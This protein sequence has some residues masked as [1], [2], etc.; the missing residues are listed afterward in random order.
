MRN[1]KIG[2]VEG[3]LAAFGAMAL[4][5]CGVIWAEAK[6]AQQ[7]A[8]A[9]RPSAVQAEEQEV[10]TSDP[11]KATVYGEG[12]LLG[13]IAIPEISL[14]APILDG[15]SH[16]TLQ[17]GAGRVPGT[18]LPGGLGNMGLAAHRDSYFRSLG[19][20]HQGTRILVSNTEGTYHY[21]VDTTEVVLPGRID[22]LDVGNVPQL[23]LITCYPFHFIGAA[24]QRFIVRAHLLSVSADQSPS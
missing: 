9:L 4:I 10:V 11:S 13:Q 24:P 8:G 19:K 23:T 16:G 5:Y 21:E 15:V 22:V 3:V 6:A 14:R 12:K 2:W 7:A 17:R 20:V 18:A 1:K